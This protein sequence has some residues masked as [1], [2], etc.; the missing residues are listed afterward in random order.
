MADDNDETDVEDFDVDDAI[1]LLLGAKPEPPETRGVIRGITRLEKLM[2]LVEKESSAT[3][4]MTERLEYK[5]HNYG[6][7]SQ[8]VYQA[9]QNLAAAGLIIDTAVQSKTDDDREVLEDAVGPDVASARYATRDFRLTPLGVRYY[10]ALLQDIDPGAVAEIA[11]IR[12]EYS[13]WPLRAL[14]R[15]VYTKYADYTSKS[16]IRRDILGDTDQELQGDA[17]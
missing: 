10:R 2:F 6:P 5:A 13:G 7:F 3:I 15:Y 14:L 12:R 11:R 1:V 4:Q 8:R 17:E 16:V 9:L